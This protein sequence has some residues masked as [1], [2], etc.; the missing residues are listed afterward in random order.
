M[1]RDA[2]SKMSTSPKETCAVSHED[3]RCMAR[4]YKRSLVGVGGI[5]CRLGDSAQR[6]QDTL[7]T[8]TRYIG[9]ATL[10]AREILQRRSRHIGRRL[11]I[12]VDH[13]QPIQ[14][15]KQS[16]PVLQRIRRPVINIPIQPKRQSLI[17]RLRICTPRRSVGRVQA[18]IILAPFV[19]CRIV[20]P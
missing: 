14:V 4:A 15:L 11:L 12:R 7:L 9:Q 10:D 18:H 20:G 8:N 3:I 17:R 13:D 2:R 5:R 19:T 6:D 16:I 1:S